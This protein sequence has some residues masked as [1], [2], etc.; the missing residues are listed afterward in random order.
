MISEPF[1]LGNTKERREMRKYF[2]CAL[3][4]VALCC[5]GLAQ[6]APPAD[7]AKPAAPAAEKATPAK[8]TPAKAAPK[9]RKYNINTAYKTTL[10]KLGLDAE[11]AAK[12]IAGRPY[13]T[14]DELVTKNILTQDQYDKIKARIY[15][16]PKPKPKASGM[17]K[18]AATTPA[19]AEKPKQ[20]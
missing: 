9:P 8:T 16:A 15:A 10:V 18:P 14:K 20:P 19:P 12:V 1:T 3:L 7:K 2:V 13:K 5:L 17:K 6:T 11:T 4:V